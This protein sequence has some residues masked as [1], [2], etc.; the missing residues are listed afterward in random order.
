M[1][2]PPCLS[3]LKKNCDFNL[4]G[5]DPNVC[6]KD[7]IPV[8]HVATLNRKFEAIPVLVQQGADVNKKGPK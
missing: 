1:T 5:A 2:R 7:D 8:L 3:L 4:Q 6:N